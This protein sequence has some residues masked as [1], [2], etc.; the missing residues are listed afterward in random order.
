MCRS[1]AVVRNTAYRISAVPGGTG[2]KA[3]GVFSSP[4]GK[5]VSSSLGTAF[6]SGENDWVLAVFY[7]N[8]GTAIETST[9]TQIQLEL[10]SVATTYTPFVPNSPSPDY[11]SPITPNVLAGDY[12][13]TTPY[14]IY[15]FTALRHAWYWWGE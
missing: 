12:K 7:A 14:G 6:N 2:I 3:Y 9:F 10:G 1:Y 11:P 5:I 13:V 4:D 15:E 8:Y